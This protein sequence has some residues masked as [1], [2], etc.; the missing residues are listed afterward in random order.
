MNVV[1]ILLATF[2]G[3]VIAGGSAAAD[4]TMVVLLDATGSMQAIRSDNR[5]RFEQAQFD[6]AE[7]ISTVAMQLEGLSQ[8]AVY[9]F[10]GSAAVCETCAPLGSPPRICATDPRRSFQTSPTGF[11][12]PFDA[13]TA[14]EC[15]TVTVQVTPLADAL[16]TAIDA[17]RSSGDAGTTTRFLEVFSDGAENNSSGVCSGPFSTI[18]NTAPFDSGP[19]P[20]W[21]NLVWTRTTNPLP[22]IQVDPTLYHDV[23]FAAK[24]A[25]A[26][27]LPASERAAAVRAF[28][29]TDADLF[30]ALA[31]ST[32]GTFTSVIDSAPAPVVADLDG[33]FDVDRNDALALARRFGQP[34]TAASDLDGNGVI[35]FGDYSRLLARFGNGSGTPAPDPYVASGPITCPVNGGTVTIE[36]KAVTGSSFAITGNQGCRI[37]IRNSLIVGD[38]A[39]I[40]MNGNNRVTVENS[41]IVGNGV[42]AVNGFTRL[43][44]SKT[45]FHGAKLE[46]NGS[47]EFYDGGGN[48]WEE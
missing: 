3:V 38:T 15:A 42:I 21:Q 24:F 9:K 1:R 43:F 5:T 39:A 36:G 35:G 30:A 20:S 31:V 25:N 41:I 8:V 23:S 27:S 18:L 46:P 12:S 2:V 37:I 29:A 6:A 22:A 19:P 45:I 48:V 34:G 16:C 33:D 32:G 40:L 28:A 4:R 47:L 10:Y 11:V 14:V 26:S 44:A 13:A 17:A 7:R